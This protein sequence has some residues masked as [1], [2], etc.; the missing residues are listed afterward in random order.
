MSAGLCIV[1]LIGGVHVYKGGSGCVNM[2]NHRT[3][4][5]LLT[6][7][8]DKGSRLFGF[9]SG[10][11]YIHASIGIDDDNKRFF[12]FRSKKG[13]S[14][15]APSKKKKDEPCILF[16]LRVSEKAYRDIVARI[17]TF[18]ANSEKY[19]FN[20]IG[21]LLCL[22]GIRFRFKDSYFCSQFVSETLNLSGEVKLRKPPELYLPK[23]FPGEPGFELCYRGTLKGLGSAF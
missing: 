2:K 18:E 20:Y 1:W 11:D 3:V 13:F 10:C 8:S 12:S 21:V 9:V 14:V 7:Y 23:F 15:E 16:R 4:S 5:V 6:K 17:R 19:R 22:L